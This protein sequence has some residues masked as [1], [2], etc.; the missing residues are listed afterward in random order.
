[1]DDPMTGHIMT[2]TFDGQ[3]AS[4]FRGICIDT[5]DSRTPTTMRPDDNL[6]PTVYSSTWSKIS[7]IGPQI[8]KLGSGTTFVGR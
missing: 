1:M 4:N 5:M 3:E 6:T 8:A 7:S 2:M